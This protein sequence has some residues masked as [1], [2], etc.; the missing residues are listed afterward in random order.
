MPSPALKKLRQSIDDILD[1]RAA[2]AA[3]SEY[4][5]SVF[6]GAVSAARQVIMS[7]PESDRP[8]R[9]LADI[10]KA[11]SALFDT[12]NDTSGEFTNG[13]AAIG[14]IKLDIARLSE[15]L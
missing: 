10:R 9:Y 12:Y 14:D 3:Q 4:D 6:I 7:V 8:E 11:L 13:R 15:D 5:R 1:R 2:S